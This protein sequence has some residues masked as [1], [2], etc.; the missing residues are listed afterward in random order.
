[1]DASYARIG[2]AGTAALAD[3]V[4]VNRTLTRLSL[5]GDD[6]GNGVRSL[7]GALKQNRTLA[8]LVLGHSSDMLAGV[9]V[10]ALRANRTLRLLDISCCKVDVLAVAAAVGHAGCA[11]QALSVPSHNLGDCTGRALIEAVAETTSLTT[12]RI[13]HNQRMNDFHLSDEVMHELHAVTSR[14]RRARELSAAQRELLR[15]EEGR[16]AVPWVAP[17]VLGIVSEYAGAWSEFELAVHRRY[18]T[19]FSPDEQFACMVREMGDVSAGR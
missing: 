13:E 19:P 8:V 4:R 14:N 17:D 9:L 6:H 7:I 16:D 10:D 15:T 18:G 1:M 12:V 3:A 11:L 5:D 2:P